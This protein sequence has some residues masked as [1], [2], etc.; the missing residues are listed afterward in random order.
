MDGSRWCPH[1]KGRTR[2]YFHVPK[3]KKEYQQSAALTLKRINRWKDAV[4]KAA[5][6]HGVPAHL[7]AAIIS[8]ETLGL[9]R[10]SLPP[11]KGQLGDRG[12][13]HGPMQIDKRSFPDWC[14]AWRAGKLST[15]DGIEKGAE[16]LATKLEEV[17]RALPSLGISQQLF[18]AVAAYNCGTSNVV[19]AHKRGLALDA[20]TT[21]KDYATDVMARAEI[22]ASAGL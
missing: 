2:H 9:D 7:V 6:K 4:R 19:A 17:K 18:A 15:E 14:A 10:W 13:G 8:R 16:V 22:F 1:P 5:D 21:G 11:P 12:Y 20:Y 3:S